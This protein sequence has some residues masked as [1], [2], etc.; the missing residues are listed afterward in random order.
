ME[1]MRRAL[2]AIGAALLLAACVACGSGGERP[3]AS[4]T[5][6]VATEAPT[7]SPSPSPTTTAMPAA[8]EAPSASATPTTPASPS[9]SP[10]ADAP[11]LPDSV[12]EV[13]DELAAL[14]GL[15]P[16]PSLRADTVS[17]DD[18]PALIEEGFSKAELA[19]FDEITT[20]YRLLGH[21]RPDQDYWSV[22][23][24]AFSG[25]VAGFYDPEGKR[26]WVVTLSAGLDDLRGWQRETLAHELLHALQDHYVDLGAMLEDRGHDLDREMAARAVVEGDAEYHTRLWAERD[27]GRGWRPAGGTGLPLR[28]LPQQIDVPEAVIREFAFPYEWGSIWAEAA[29]E[30]GGLDAINAAL[31]DPP[32]TTAHI[33]HPD[34]IAPDWTPEAVALPPLADAL[35]E[36][37]RLESEGPL[38][39]FQLIN[40]LLPDFSGPPRR[41]DDR[42]VAAAEAAAGWRGDWHA[43]YVNGGESVMAARVRFADAEEAREFDGTHRAIELADAESVTEGALTLATRADGVTVALAEPSGH[44]ILFAIGSNAAIARAAL[45]ALLGG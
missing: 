20:L 2:A 22:L 45:E 10:A 40:Y 42:A 14:R 5:P 7:A 44:D 41:D 13:L 27:G 18:L 11:P 31:R 26:L 32:P 12:R 35:G 24:E 39:E 33:I 23:R 19:R 25:G 37:W 38:G 17:R 30:R 28:G 1:A 9:P 6:S 34:A 3:A 21:L 16:P 36:G 43:V 4:P 15:D 8:T 29:I